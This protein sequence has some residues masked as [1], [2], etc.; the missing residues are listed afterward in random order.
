MVYPQTMHKPSCLYQILESSVPM[1][2][3]VKICL[4]VEVWVPA[5][6]DFHELLVTESYSIG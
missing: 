6:G 5:D 3:G 1:T 2:I 4:I